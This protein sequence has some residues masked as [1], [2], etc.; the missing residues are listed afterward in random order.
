V[1]K[2]NNLVLNKTLILVVFVLSFVKYIG[3]EILKIP[4]RKERGFN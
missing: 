1:L 4:R 3:V 2:S